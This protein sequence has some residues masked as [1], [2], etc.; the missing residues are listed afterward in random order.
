MMKLRMKCPRH[1]QLAKMMPQLP[2]G[3]TLTKTA[4]RALTR[5]FTK[6]K[7]K[8]KLGEEPSKPSK[9]EAE[10]EPPQTRFTEPGMAKAKF[11]QLGLA[12][13]RK[14]RYRDTEFLNTVRR[15]Y[16]NSD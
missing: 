6:A 8:V 12:I 5:K 1:E 3:P 7:S 14:I 13:L 4:Q 10:Q 9:K 16:V 15:T 2:E 11:R